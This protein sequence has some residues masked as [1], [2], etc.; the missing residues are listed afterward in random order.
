MRREMVCSSLK[1]KIYLFHSTTIAIFLQQYVYFEFVKNMRKIKKRGDYLLYR[2]LANGI[3]PQRKRAMER[4]TALQGFLERIKKYIAFVLLQGIKF[5]VQLAEF[6][7]HNVARGIVG[8]AEG[9]LVRVVFGHADRQGCA[10]EIKVLPVA[11]FV[12]AVDNVRA[13]VAC[14]QHRAQHTGNQKKTNDF[15]HTIFSP[16]IDF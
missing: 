11:V 4:S 12:A 7:F 16:Y 3:K 15:F 6:L 5:G 8:G 10:L 14:D 2:S 1:K 9:G 13:V